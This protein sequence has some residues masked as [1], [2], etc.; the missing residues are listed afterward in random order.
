MRM[1]VLVISVSCWINTTHGLSWL[2]SRPVKDPSGRYNAWDLTHTFPQPYDPYYNLRLCNNDRVCGRHQFCD[3]H[4]GVCREQFL[5]GHSCRR[6]PMCQR[7]LDCMLGTCQPHV[8]RGREGARCHK[9]R[10]CDPE[11]CCARHQGQRICQRLLPQDH[12]C[13]VPDGG[14]DYFINERCPCQLGLICKYTSPDPPSYD[15]SLTFLSAYDNMRCVPPSHSPHH[16]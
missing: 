13:F 1:W 6:D 9:N 11:L 4:F 2:F 8:E 15:P 7:G 14:V 16:T 12:K 3:L 5:E 10:N